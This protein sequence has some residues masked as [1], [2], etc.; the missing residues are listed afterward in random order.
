MSA[1]AHSRLTRA[2]AEAEAAAAALVYA[3]AAE[4]ETAKAAEASEGSGT[5]APCKA[6]DGA[7]SAAKALH[8][9]ALDAEDA[10][11][12]VAE[13][14]LL[15]ELVLRQREECARPPTLPADCHA[16]L[17][18]LAAALR[19]IADAQLEAVSKR[20]SSADGAAQRAGRAEGAE[21]VEPGR[22]SV[23]RRA[24]LDPV[25]QS[26]LQR[27]RQVLEGELSTLD[28]IFPL[29]AL[30]SGRTEGSGAG[31]AVAE[32]D[33]IDRV[34]VSTD[35]ND[36]S[37]S[38][39]DCATPKLEVR[40]SLNGLA[41]VLQGISMRVGMR[42]AILERS[43]SR[44]I[45]RTVEERVQARE[46]ERA[47]ERAADSAEAAAKAAAEAAAEAEDRLRS[48]LEEGERRIAQLEEEL[49]H[50]R[51][52]GELRLAEQLEVTAGAEARA[53]HLEADNAELTR[54]LE[55]SERRNAHLVE[56]LEA[57]EE[58]AAKQEEELLGAGGTLFQVIDIAVRS[59]EASGEGEEKE[60]E[61]TTSDDVESS[62]SSSLGPFPRGA[63]EEAEAA[64]EAGEEEEAG[65]AEEAVA[66][67]E[68][69]EEEGHALEPALEPVP[70]ETKAE[71]VET[72]ESDAAALDGGCNRNDGAAAEHKEPKP[73]AGADDVDPASCDDAN[74][75]GE[76][77]EE[78]RKRRRK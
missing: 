13:L 2:E 72:A 22:T 38:G 4:A 24:A 26:G 10:E 48:V 75:V 30:V 5:R 69:G 62:S 8:L 44:A 32:D 42:V 73:R 18:R 11:A 71:V 67:E 34:A 74:D 56:Q 78:R 53:A 63:A 52:L 65:A 39:D 19:R 14:R 57:A 36:A 40:A 51:A 68:A 37:Q 35:S 66:A 28:D 54:A 43:S 33:S 9:A 60:G 23:G 76:E 21:G 64:E 31:D 7:Q 58:C 27:L 70:I 41:S 49:R 16:I 77:E 29:D 55:R 12:E 17:S 46:T 45:E 61:A 25:A 15:L 47:A 20:M 3:E 50:E 6:E 1:V 59:L